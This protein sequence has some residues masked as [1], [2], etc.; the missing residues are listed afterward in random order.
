MLSRLL[1]TKQDGKYFVQ[2]TRVQKARDA[3]PEEIIRQLFVLSLLHDYKYP[4]E[5]IS[6]QLPIQMGSTK[7][8]AD[9]AVLDSSGNAK[10]IIEVK[11]ERDNDS[12]P[13]LRSYMA[14]TGAMYG[15]IVSGTEFSCVQ[16]LSAQDEKRINDLPVFLGTDALPPEMRPEPNPRPTPRIP[17]DIEHFE[18]IT[19]THAKITIEG[20][21]LQL[22]NTEL[23][24]FKRLR[25]KFL[26]VGVVLDTATEAEWS[27]R[28][29]Q[30]LKNTP[31]PLSHVDP[32]QSCIEEYL[33][34]AAPDE[35]WKAAFKNNRPFIQ[36][37]THYINSS[38]LH[39]WIQKRLDRILA[40]EDVFAALRNSG[41]RPKPV[42]LRGGSGN[43]T[44]KRYWI[45][46]FTEGELSKVSGRKPSERPDLV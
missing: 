1:F 17:F 24:S 31:A 36:S 9:I 35:R 14:I 29:R 39:G 42:G 20:H 5:Q 41:W 22:S 8:F 10:I 25:A 46:R 18:R 13:Q 45:K 21:T 3:G 4:E 7:K 32:I 15:A 19:P 37:N 12:M 28:V 40:R 11:V 6:V 26:S 23:S 30:L 33:Q 27:E 34:D 2:A 44:T 16:R 43:T 38:D